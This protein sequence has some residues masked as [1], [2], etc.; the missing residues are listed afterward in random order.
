MLFG[1]KFYLIA[2]AVALVALVGFGQVQYWRGY[3]AHKAK[4]K[5]QISESVKQGSQARERALDDLANDRV[6]DT[7]FRD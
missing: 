1:L 3:N 2:G 7:W 4:I 5:A 6:P